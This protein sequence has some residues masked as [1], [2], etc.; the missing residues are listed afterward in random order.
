MSKFFIHRPIFAI[1]IALIIVIGG[2]LS[3]VQL[4]IAQY[5]QIAPPT[6]SVS[7]TYI[8]ANA[9][10][11][12]EA[13]AQI[14]E[15]Q[16]NGTQGMDYMNSD[17]DDTGSYSLSVVFDLGTDGDM[18]AVKVQNNVAVANSSLPGSVKNVGVTTSK[19]SN[20][21]AYM[22]A[23]YSPNNTYDRPWLKNYADIYILDK[24][25]R[26]PGVGSV[27]VFGSDYAM[28][29]WCNPA[30]MAEMGIT[31]A[32]ISAAIHDQNVQAPAG[33]VGAMPVPNGQEK[34]STGK[35]DGRLVTAE[36][37][38][39]IILK[40]NA[41]GQ[42]VRLKDVAKV[43]TGSKDYS[44]NGK[45]NNQDCVAF[46]VQLTN[47]ANTMVAVAEVRK[48]L[49]ESRAEFPPDL[50]YK[51]IVDSTDFINASITEVVETF[52]EALLLVVLVVFIFLQNWRATLIPLLA[53][54]VSLIGTFIAFIILDFSIN[55]LT[56]FAMVL[57]IGLVV[58]D[59]IVV[60]ENVEAHMAKG[61]NPIDA[62]ERAM[63]EV[64]G[65]VVAI[66]FVL[67]AVFVPVAFLGG[68][69]GVPYRQ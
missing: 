19:S 60:I 49:E 5:P 50:D 26:V 64:Q 8:G 35:I 54:P 16:V 1:V 29:V 12:N 44:V 58:D 47:D 23:L 53:V 39:N 38:G 65:P 22:M 28:R 24:I 43:E 37:F 42:Y 46:G 62:T 10:T 14:I 68:T 11:V 7:T 30:K 36:E 27:M 32:E 9:K 57:A 59:A 66:A 21:M 18:D 6:V 48:I 31:A 17:S 63:D 52:V 34:Q 13:V 25:K 56:L 69:I 67:A 4:P 61:L 41:D 45:V 20:S 33:S 3:A 55:T 2:V 40:A 15:Q 51:E